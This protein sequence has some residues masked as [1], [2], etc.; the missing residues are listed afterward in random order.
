MK[1]N[2]STNNL[3]PIKTGI[4]VDTFTVAL[5]FF[6]F[7]EIDINLCFTIQNIQL[8]DTTIINFFKLYN[9]L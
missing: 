4:S 7:V 3:N 9:S 8:L 5:N 1:N 2:N 6:F